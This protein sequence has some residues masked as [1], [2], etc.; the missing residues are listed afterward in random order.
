MNRNK[1]NIHNIDVPTSK[2]Q[3]SLS[4]QKNQSSK[5]LFS[6]Y[7]L[8]STKG[9]ANVSLRNIADHAK[10]VLSQVNYYFK[11]KEGLMAAVVK[12]M[13]DKFIQ[14]IEEVLKNGDSSKEKMMSL[15]QY[16]KDILTTN[17]SLLRI[18]Y[19]LTAMSLWSDKFSKLL[20]GLFEKLT[21]LIQTYIVDAMIQENIHKS[22]STEGLSRMI[23]GAMIGTTIQ[24]LL[25]PDI[26]KIDKSLDSINVLFE[27]N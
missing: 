22:P 26:E 13:A 14:E 15:T 24:F 20:D 12:M 6:A 5:I 17:P 2:V 10:V 21:S 8:V 18:F 3:A 16:Y 7:E 27:S 19:D 1:Q 11:N 9:Y 23:L 4:D 25:N